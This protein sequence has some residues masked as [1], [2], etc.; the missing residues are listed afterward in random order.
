[1]HSDKKCLECDGC[2]DI[3]WLE[4]RRFFHCRFCNLFYDIEDNTFVK[5]DVY[6]LMGV[7]K[8]E[9]DAVLYN[10]GTNRFV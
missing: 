1:M 8:A 4:P 6:T 9:L 5:V 10:V 7:A 2:T 3:I